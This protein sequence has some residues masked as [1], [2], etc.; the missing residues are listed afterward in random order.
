MLFPAIIVY[1]SDLATRDKVY[2]DWGKAVERSMNTVAVV[3]FLVHQQFFLQITRSPKRY[4]IEKFPAYRSDESF[5]KRVR[6]RHLGETY[7]LRH[8]ENSELGVPM[9]KKE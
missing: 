6:K 1:A 7:Y 8:L 5:N 2:F 9:A 4:L 3:V